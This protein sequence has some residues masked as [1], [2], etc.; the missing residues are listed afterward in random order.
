MTLSRDAG[1]ASLEQQFREQVAGFSY[2]GQRPVPERIAPVPA[3]VSTPAASGLAGHAAGAE[4]TW[5][6]ELGLTI[7]RL[8]DKVAALKGS[9]DAQ[10]VA[11]QELHPFDLPFSAASQSAAAGQTLTSETWGP[12]TGWAWDVRR[13]TIQGLNGPS[14]GV[15][16]VSTA[17]GAIA[18]GAGTAALGNGVSATGFTLSFSAAPSLTGTAVLSNVTGGPYTFNIPSGQTSPYTVNFPQPITAASA[19]VAP[20]LTIAGLGTGAGTIVLYGTSTTAIVPGDVV[21]VFKAPVAAPA[22]AVPLAAIDN[23]TGSGAGSDLLITQKG[24]FLLQQGDALL[25]AGAYTAANIAVSAS[26]AEVALHRV[27]WYLK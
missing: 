22:G 19:G 13:V 6:A 14:G 4:L 2:A 21:T 5:Q 17:A 24:A 23:I 16:T 25:I 8:A 20:T 26:G 11:W 1:V 12:R 9:H 15:T 10:R 3:V 18:A 7:G 27:P